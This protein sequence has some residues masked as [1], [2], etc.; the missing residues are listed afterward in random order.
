MVSIGGKTYGIRRVVVH[1]EWVELGP[2]D[3]GLIQLSTPV[4]GVSPLPLYE[5]RDEAGQIAI[6][7]GHGDTRSGKGGPWQQDGLV[8]GATGKVESSG[9]GHLVFRFHAPPDGTDL[10]GAPGRGDSGG[11][12]LLEAGGRA[13]VAGV[14][15]AGF[16]G[17]AGPG[18]YGA[19][20]HFTRVSDHV[21]W[22]RET[23]R[24]AK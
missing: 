11:P 18:T 12:A 13:F 8:R 7:V 24:T 22:I 19:V 16:D 17:S 23:I 21:E 2:H 4:T 1:P 20:D 3:I 14:S 15:S 9:G 6:L 5:G 10:E